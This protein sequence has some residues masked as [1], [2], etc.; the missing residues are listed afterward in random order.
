MSTN[1]RSKERES[2]KKISAEVREALLRLQNIC[3]LIFRWQLVR[4]PR[5]YAALLAAPV[6][7]PLARIAA[8]A[9]ARRAAPDSFDRAVKIAQIITTAALFTILAAHAALAVSL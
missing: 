9:N 4:S 1:F 2:C 6:I 7:D 5:D 3:S 8:Q